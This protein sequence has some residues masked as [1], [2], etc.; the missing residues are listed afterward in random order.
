MRATK[1][2]AFKTR[3]PATGYIAHYLG[4]QTSSDNTVTDDSGAGNHGLKNS[5]STGELWSTA[6]RFA[7]VATANK[8]V[9]LP[10]D[11]ENVWRWNATHRDSLWV[12]AWVGVTIGSGTGVFM[13][14]AN[15]TSE[16]GLKWAVG[17]GGILSMALYDK[18]N[19]ISIASGTVF[20]DASW[21][22][23]VMH[24]VDTFL[25]GVNNTYSMYVDGA[26]VVN[27]ASLA[28]ATILEPTASS[29]DFCVGSN[30][31][32]ATGMTA[33]FYDFHMLRAPHGTQIR[34]ADLLAR[35]LYRTPGLI[36]A[37][38]WV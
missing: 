6:S 22:T 20:T 27:A 32:G 3:T 23:T 8:H 25:D 15:G 2:G 35:R 24:R 17:V 29:Y 18:T 21:S 11:A 1:L 34:D 26:R 30:Q 7:S 33:L 12:G 9:T 37:S 31:P 5:M 4:F 14:N 13:G 38:E 28:T 19:V 36:D 16:G 10:T